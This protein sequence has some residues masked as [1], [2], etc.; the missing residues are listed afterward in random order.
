MNETTRFR[1]SVIEALDALMDDTGY[2]RNKRSRS[3][4]WRL[5]LSRTQSIGMHLSFGMRESAADVSIIPSAWLRDERL[6]KLE[7]DSGIRDAKYASEGA[8][9]GR[10]IKSRGGRNFDCSTEQNP[11]EIAQSVFDDFRVYGLPYLMRLTDA[12][13]AIQNLKSDVVEDWSVNS[14]S[15]RSPAPATSFGC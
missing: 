10:T 2:K 12:E 8:Q 4:S 14:R 5:K 6:L 15:Q 3:Q 7:V 1:D 13:F 9:F 11:L